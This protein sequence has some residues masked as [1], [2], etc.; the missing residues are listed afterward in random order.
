MTLASATKNEPPLVGDVPTRRKDTAGCII[1]SKSIHKSHRMYHVVKERPQLLVAITNIALNILSTCIRG[2]VTIFREIRGTVREINTG[3]W[4]PRGKI[5]SLVHWRPAA[6]SCV[7]FFVDIL[8]LYLL[9][10]IPR[11]RTNHHGITLTRLG[12]TQANSP[13]QRLFSKTPYRLMVP[14][15]IRSVSASGVRLDVLLNKLF[16]RYLLQA[17][18]QCRKRKLVRAYTFSSRSLVSHLCSSCVM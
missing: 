11:D 13:Q 15:V 14:S 16:S 3:R 17:C 7:R 6:D 9:L 12:W 10:H 4:V 1:D 8:H 2:P 18:H 5:P